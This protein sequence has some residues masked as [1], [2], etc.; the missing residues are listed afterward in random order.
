LPA[1]SLS[2]GLLAT[3]GVSLGV[4]QQRATAEARIVA[5][6][7]PIAPALAPPKPQ[8]TQTKVSEPR[9]DVPPPAETQTVDNPYIPPPRLYD[10]DHGRPM[11]PDRDARDTKATY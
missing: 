2:L 8:V 9:Y 7:Q 5:N 4:R 1:F 6:E 3:L 10:L 11:P